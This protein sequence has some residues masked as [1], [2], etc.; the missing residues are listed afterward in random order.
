MDKAMRLLFGM[1]LFSAFVLSCG[2]RRLSPAELQQKLDSVKAIEVREHLEAQGIHFEEVNPLQAF[3]DSLSVQTLPVSYT[4]IYVKY[5]PNYKP[6]PP[7]LVAYL[8]LEGKGQPKAV[9]L[10]E[11]VGVRLMLLAADEED[12]EYSLWLYSLDNDY[13]P[14][15]KL[16]LYAADSADSEDDPS[17]YYDMDPDEVVQYFYI[18]SDYE[19]RLLDYSKKAR[20]AEAEEVYFVDAGRKFIERKALTE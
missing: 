2:G 12:G 20:K 15:D 8:N 11:T 13:L 9:S 10:P 1:L 19:I 14:V 4:D 7:E 18:T 16:C 5:L 3:Y 17:T 6:V